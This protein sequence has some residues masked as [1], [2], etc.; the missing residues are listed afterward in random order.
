MESS[1][2]QDYDK[3]IDVY[4]NKYKHLH[5]I[6]LRFKR[7]IISYKCTILDQSPIDPPENSIVILQEPCPPIKTKSQSFLLYTLGKGPGRRIKDESVNSLL[8]NLFPSEFILYSHFSNLT[9]FLVATQNPY[10][11]KMKRC[12]REAAFHALMG[13]VDAKKKDDP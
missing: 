5:F 1:P 11:E 12:R 8:R 6:A 10:Y 2:L 3:F 7:A 13:F 9:L 4:G